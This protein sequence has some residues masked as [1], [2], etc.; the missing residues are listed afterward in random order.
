LVSNTFSQAYVVPLATLA[1]MENGRLER[2]ERRDQILLPTGK[3]CY[4]NF[5][6]VASGLWIA[7]NEKNTSLW[8]IFQVHK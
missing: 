7:D 1:H 4:A 2:T 5:Q 8:V 6:N 3:K